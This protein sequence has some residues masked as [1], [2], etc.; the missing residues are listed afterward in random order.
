[1]HSISLQ[2]SDS[3]IAVNDI[4][5]RIGFAASNETGSDAI[6]VSALILAVAEGTFDST[7][8]PTSLTFSTGHSETATEKMRIDSTGNVGIGLTA[9]TQKLEVDGKSKADLH[10]IDVQSASSL[11][12]G[13]YTIATNV[14]NRAIGRFS[15]TCESSGRHQGIVFY[16]SHYYSLG[17]Q[18]SVLHN[19]TYASTNPIAKLR[20][21]KGGTYEGCMLQ[22][23]IDDA[24]NN[25]SVC[26]LNDNVNTAGWIVKD[27]IADGVDPGNLSNFSNLTTVA[28]EFDLDEADFGTT[29]LVSRF[30]DILTGQWAGDS[31]YSGI[32]HRDF[33]S[34]AYMMISNGASTFVG[35]GAGGIT[36]IRG[37][38]NNVA[39]GE[40]RL[41]SGQVIVNE[42]GANV[43]FRVEGDTDQNL[44]RADA[45]T[46]NVGIGYYLP[47]EKLQV[48][49]TVKV[50]N[51]GGLG[52]EDDGVHM[53]FPGGATDK[54]S[55]STQTGYLKVSLPTSWSNTMI[56]FDLDVYEYNANG[57]AALRKF[58][59]GGYNHTGQGGRWV[60]QVAIYDGTG[61]IN[62]KCKI[63]FGHDGT[64]CAIYIS[65]M[66]AT[67]VDSGAASSWSYVQ[68]YVSNFF[69]GYTNDTMSRWADGWD[70]TYTTTLGTITL[71]S[72]VAPSHK[73]EDIV[74]IGTT[75]QSIAPNTVG[76]GHGLHIASDS[77]PELHL[78]NDTTGHASS[79]GANIQLNT[80]KLV[81]LNRETTGLIQA[82]TSATKLNF[83]L[84]SS[85]SCFNES[86]DDID[87]RVEGDTEASLFFVDAS[88]DRVGIKT[89]L[90]QSDFEVR[91]T[92]HLRGN[93]TL[94]DASIPIV[95][96]P[97][98]A[99]EEV[100]FKE[101]IIAAK[102]ITL[103]N[104]VPSTTTNVLYN[105]AGTLMWDGSEVGSGGGSSNLI[106]GSFAIT[107]STSVFTVSGGYSTGSLDVYQ[108]GIKLFKGSSYDFTETGGGT[109]FTLANAATNGDLIE[110][111]ALN[112]ST[113]AT[114]NTSLGSVS[115]TSNQTVFNTSDT[116]TSSN[117]AVF[118]NGVKLVDGTDYNVT[119]S[120]QFTLT[121]TAVSGD[122]VEYIAYGATVAS[123]NLSKTGDTMTGNLTVNAD[124]IVTGYK[125]THTD[126]GNTGTSQTIDISDSTIQTYTL[127]G[128]C[129]FTMPTAEA[130]R[131]FTIFLK[132]GAGNLTATFTNVK[133]PQNA[134]PAITINASR[135]DII[136]F[137]SD[138][139]NWYGSI[140]QDYY[141]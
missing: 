71:T 102:G 4:L 127:N 30:D 38:S 67:G 90:P 136:T 65:K 81:L 76:A 51:G 20:I 92:S 49:G 3:S 2:S 25:V 37:A 133:F 26:L 111:V 107:T 15:L 59:I 99:T 123:S 94:G 22:V 18:I 80:N 56:M 83:N 46:D 69:A 61:A 106:R 105:D 100:Y 48:H 121:S 42:T 36:Y 62:H 44:I 53:A 103:N 12:V 64:N 55:S 24:T 28:S 109:T 47:S 117:L 16:A 57:L 17:T 23:Y 41:S 110:Y 52:R 89:Q 79:A 85:E 13:W 82:Y 139:T 33:L 34:N 108:N 113:S 21:K 78:T 135:M 118:L 112:A 97:I 5:G 138:G 43:D 63:H 126:N 120:S 45:S 54:N 31:T 70:I 122:V 11:A 68:S 1:M 95:S 114:G 86:G 19:N 50:S 40:I 60:R 93:V 130:G 29:A 72:E 14:G 32:T 125:E 137:Y 39:N 116:F 129:T 88:T 9:P 115:V 35:C 58:K 128:N 132:T 87:F 119:S 75:S 84:S 91:G 73:Q 8:N 27:W 10:L 124:L 96:S 7:N 141:I 74:G 134:S 98:K 66:S 77:F 131:S 104:S 140:Q 101:N 6:K